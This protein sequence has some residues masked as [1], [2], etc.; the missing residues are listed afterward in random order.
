MKCLILGGS[1][2]LG[3]ALAATAPQSMDLAAPPRADCDITNAA[4]SQSCFDAIRPALVINT[5]GYTDV[6]GAQSHA[7]EA[8]A[9]NAQGPG[10]LAALCR[11]QGARL[12]HLSTDFVFDGAARTPYGEDAAPHPLNEYGSGKYEG[13]QLVRRE[14]PQSLIVRTAWL[15]AEQG[16]NF[17]GT[18]L[19]LMAARDEVKVVAD[20]TGTPTYARN[21]AAALWRLAALEESGL[22]HFTDEGETSWHG[23]ALAIRDEAF[24]LGL[25]TRKP[26]VIAISSR[27]FPSPAQRP[28]YSVLDKSKIHAKIG[29]GMDWRAALK[30][31]L[32]AKKGSTRP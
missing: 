10:A 3:R 21:L 20:Q 1:G 31:M 24:A 25:L 6:N 17:V 15:Y 4:Q 26:D 8:R 32:A 14:H 30:D 19:G 23:F 16:R 22:Y 12:I 5:A 27:D 11:R 2:Q 28:A 18:M 9:V 13:E 7:V 29:V